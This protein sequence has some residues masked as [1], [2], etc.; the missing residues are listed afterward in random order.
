MFYSSYSDNLSRKISKDILSLNLFDFSYVINEVVS[1][2][3]SVFSSYHLY[4]NNTDIK[5]TNAFWLI[6]D[7]IE[8]DKLDTNCFLPEILKVNSN[9]TVGKACEILIQRRLAAKKIQ[10]NMQ[11]LVSDPVSAMLFD[12]LI[13][14]ALTCWA[15]TNNN[16]KFV[17]NEQTEPYS[18]HPLED[19]QY[20][21]LD[22][23][24]EKY[25]TVP[26][27]YHPMGFKNA[28]VLDKKMVTAH[29][30][31]Y[32]D[33]THWSFISCLFFAE[34]KDLYN[35]ACIETTSYISEKE[36]Y[37]RVTSAKNSKEAFNPIFIDSMSKIFYIELS[38]KYNSKVQ[39]QTKSENDY[40]PSWFNH[41]L[42][43]QLVYEKDNAYRAPS[44]YKP[45]VIDTY[46][47]NIILIIA[48]V[49]N[50]YHKKFRNNCW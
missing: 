32:N 27:Y 42:D 28:S 18:F 47:N 16:G 46:M 45:E 9:F 21:A 36:K 40:E 4:P 35:A 19:V 41:L 7:S 23:H 1:M 12:L 39:S 20:Y 30:S 31:N 37:E 5:C 50:Y 49:Y 38:K 25:K 48:C 3:L 22:D 11:F 15:A 29:H 24:D 34:Y 8:S 17:L 33:Y 6:D 26:T 2:P 14:P 43:N 13:R 44:Y 10:D